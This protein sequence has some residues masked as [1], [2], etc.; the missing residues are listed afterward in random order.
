[1]RRPHL[2]RSVAMMVAMQK[3]LRAKGVIPAGRWLGA[4]TLGTSRTQERRRPDR[5]GAVPAQ[6]PIQ[7]K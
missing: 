6:R 5:S 3:Y 2:K 7:P 4:G 1:M